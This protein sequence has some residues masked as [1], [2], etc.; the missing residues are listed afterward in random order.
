MRYKGG[1]ADG[2]SVNSNFVAL[3]GAII[4]GRY[5]GGNSDGY[6]AISTFTSFSGLINAFRFKGGNAD[7]YSN[8]SIFNSLSGAIIA[9][10][11]KGG[12][13]DGYTVNSLFNNLGGVISSVR[14]RGGTGDG[15]SNTSLDLNSL[16]VEL[17]LFAAE[18]FEKRNVKLNWK[19]EMEQN[20]SG[21]EIQRGVYSTDNIE[22]KKIGYVSGAG[23][24]NITKEY[25]YEDKKIES[26]K[27]L[28]RLKQ[29]DN[30]GAHNYY[31][32]SAPI[33]VGIPNKFA[34]SQNY[35]N[36]FN[37]STKIDIDLPKDAVVNLKIYDI[38]GREIA[39]LING[40]KMTAGYYTKM[41]N[42]VSLSSGTYFY[43][44]QS[45][46]EIISKRMI[47]VK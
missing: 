10:K 12:N 24:T 19:T 40:E 29:I 6:S 18:I 35:P 47:F 16:P 21:F 7:G 32:L 11:Y 20:N 1:N 42:A 45:G 8:N 33:E 41:F 9:G 39:V 26:G 27:Y 43:V 17:S 34:V 31:V 30:N 25:T 22:W 5:T 44:V 14:F 23:T 37:P 46:A 4:S 3:S 36:P 38:A 13:Y 2:Y 15:F 28:Y